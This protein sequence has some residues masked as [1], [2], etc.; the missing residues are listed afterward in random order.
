MYQHI[1]FSYRRGRK[2]IY[3]GI[4]DHVMI[5]GHFSRHYCWVFQI[6]MFGSL[7]SPSEVPSSYIIV[8]RG[9]IITADLLK[10]DQFTPKTQMSK[11]PK[12]SE[13]VSVEFR[14]RVPLTLH[15]HTQ[16][17]HV[18]VPSLHWLDHC[19]NW[20]DVDTV[21]GL[22][23]LYSQKAA[24]WIS[25]PFRFWI[26]L[27]HTWTNIPGNKRLK[28]NHWTNVVGLEMPPVFTMLVCVDTSNAKCIPSWCKTQING[29]KTDS[30]VIV[31]LL[32]LFLLNYV[33]YLVSREQ[34][35]LFTTVIVIYLEIKRGEKRR[36]RN[37]TDKKCVFVLPYVCGSCYFSFC[38]CFLSLQ[39]L[40]PL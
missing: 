7:R 6:N 18:S 40:L 28:R 2:H 29:I 1:L 16:H 37:W 39:F 25:L 33:V 8:K 5:S 35:N 31:F 13:N 30:F 19:P 24:A 12:M 21:T 11:Y 22:F 4:H 27:L 32:F 20:S 3:Y 14:G 15:S 17:T 9:W 26:S 23:N 38:F 36:L 34:G 10:T